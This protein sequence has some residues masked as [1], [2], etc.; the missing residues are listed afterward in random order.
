MVAVF[1]CQLRLLENWRLTWAIKTSLLED[2]FGMSF[3]FHESFNP[4]IQGDL[5]PVKNEPMRTI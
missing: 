1:L 5:S 2:I 3:L 4:D